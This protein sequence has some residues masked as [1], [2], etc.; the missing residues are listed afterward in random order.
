MDWFDIVDDAAADA[1]FPGVD[2][3]FR[4]E[5]LVVGAVLALAFFSLQ[6]DP[7]IAAA[8]AGSQLLLIGYLIVRRRLRHRSRDGEHAA[9]IAKSA[10]LRLARPGEFDLYSL[11]F[12]IFRSGEWQ[13]FDNVFVGDWGDDKV[14]I[15]DTWYGFEVHGHDVEE[16]F[17]CAAMEIRADCP[18]LSITR[19]GPWSRTWGHLGWRDIEVESEDFNRR[20]DVS[21][22]DERFAFAFLAPAMIQWLQSTPPEFEFAVAGR[23]L[24]CRSKHLP[25][26]RWWDLLRMIRGLRGQLPETLTRLWPDIVTP[27]ASSPVQGIRTP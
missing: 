14:W 10:G 16:H 22:D 21:G 13:G 7:L 20:F 27:R 19:E 2:E 12:P 18:K 17:T 8:L 26:E 23:W 5:Y 25:T 3:H 6:Y 9:R 24:L 15:F 4:F 1:A 11:P